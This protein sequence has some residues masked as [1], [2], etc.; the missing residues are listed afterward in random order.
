MLRDSHLPLDLPSSLRTFVKCYRMV[1]EAYDHRAKHWRAAGADPYFTNYLAA[2]VLYEVGIDEEH[3]GF[4]F[5]QDWFIKS[6]NSKGIW[7]NEGAGLELESTARA[8]VAL[9]LD[10]ERADLERVRTALEFLI[11]QQ[12]PQGWWPG[13]F[14][15]YRSSQ[16]YYGTM[17]PISFALKLS[18]AVARENDVS[19]H[20]INDSRQRLCKFIEERFDR[21]DFS[22]M[23]V[24][25]E[26]PIRAASWGTRI[27]LNAGGER[28][29]IL[30]TVT[31][32]MLGF[33]HTT[34]DIT[35]L[36]FQ[37]LYNVVHSLA[38]LGVSLEERAV[39]IACHE[40]QR[41]VEK[42]GLGTTEQWFRYSGGLVLA[43]LKLWGAH[44]LSQYYQQF[45]KPMIENATISKPTDLRDFVK[46]H[47]VALAG[48]LIGFVSAIIALVQLLK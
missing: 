35:K 20:R 2:W 31:R 42:A 29:D 5:A 18:S 14:V 45:L 41:R 17:L 3:E 32:Q 7:G 43:Y 27:Y 16:P 12:A 38:L 30:K 24:I 37:D 46:K 26:N 8:C 36:E 10:P 22:K 48:L 11:E 47:W 34:P 39:A 6:R 19:T 23:G 21:G 9:L 13:E 1:L 33:L 44:T 40:L 15:Q 4:R 25:E 28:N